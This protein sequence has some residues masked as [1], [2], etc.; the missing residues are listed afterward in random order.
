MENEAPMKSPSFGRT[1]LLSLLLTAAVWTFFHW[2]MLPRLTE[3]VPYMAVNETEIPPFNYMEPGDH[4]QL[5]YHF[6]LFEDMLRGRTPWFGNLYEFNLG[7]DAARREPGTYY[8]PFSLFFAAGDLA[9]GRAFGWNLAGFLSLW[10]TVLFTVALLRRFLRQEAWV[11]GLAAIAILIPYR[12]YTL[13]GGSPSGFAMCWPPLLFLGLDLA[14]REEKWRG[15]LL[16]GLA[17]LLMSW[18]DTHAFFFGLL[19]SPVWCLFALLSRERMPDCPRGW[20]R[21]ALRLAPVALF[22]AAA[23][24]SSK[25]MTGGA[26]SVRTARSWHDVLLSSP[27]HSGFFSWDHLGHSNHVFVGG[28]VAA[29]LLAGCIA[30]ASLFFRDR[31][32]RRDI[33]ALGLLVV[34]I[35]AIAELATGAHGWHGLAMRAARKLIPKYD[36]IRQ[37]SKIFTILPPLLTVAIALSV[38]AVGD[39]FRSRRTAGLLCAG[40]LCFSSAEFL[41]QFHL[42]FCLVADRQLA[43]AAVAG[44]AAKQGAR[45]H[46]LVLP[47][48]P[49]D[50]HFTAVY[51]HFASLYRIRMVNGYRPFVPASYRVDF[52]RSFESAN[53]GEISDAQLDDLQKRGVNAV[54]LHEDMFPEKVSPVP[55]TFTLKNLLNHPRLTLLAHDGPVWAWRIESS[56]RPVTPA[57]TNWTQ[58]FPTQKAAKKSGAPAFDLQPGGEIVFPAP[59][60]FHAGTIN[61]ERDSVVFDPVRERL[62]IVCYGPRWR[63]SP[64]RYEMSVQFDSPAPHQIVGE[65]DLEHPEGRSRHRFTMRGGETFQEPFIVHEEGVLLLIFEYEQTAPVEIRSVTIRRIE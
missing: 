12:W 21:I 14:V 26:T 24:L 32:R 44:E 35:L 1:L 22:L 49:G 7:D 61:L 56:A 6:W 4:L 60:F 52:F 29:L 59:V 54:I 62:G 8:F 48:W 2:T 13:A 40:L 30:G 5:M 25:N 19:F 34:A 36:M 47:L 33:F 45:P 39:T 3:A 10:L 11:W 37:A 51:Q 27:V 38:R 18:G 16:A 63:I 31:R 53:L 43:Y 20:L 58:R 17:V 65:W 55:V 41:R 46:A 50:A 57:G 64:G 15:G 28:G 9:A 42:R 23:M